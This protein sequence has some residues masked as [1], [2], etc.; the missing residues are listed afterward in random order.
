ML[1]R[2]QFSNFANRST[3]NRASLAF[4]IKNPATTQKH[5]IKILVLQSTSCYSMRCSLIYK[6]N[7]IIL[8][9]ND[10][11]L[12]KNKLLKKEKNIYTYGH[13]HSKQHNVHKE[14]KSNSFVHQ[15][16]SHIFYHH[17]YLIDHMMKKQ[18][19]NLH[20]YNFHILYLH[21]SNYFHSP[22]FLL[23][24]MGSFLLMMMMTPPLYSCVL[25]IR[26]GIS[27]S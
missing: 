9:D 16:K 18:Y 5:L 10:L 4:L 14:Q 3:A 23:S 15:S 20:Y 17:K 12:N 19:C 1:R 7:I 26:S 11:I 2:K 8:K 24:L 22:L 6:N 25:Q 27:L 13:K 21:H